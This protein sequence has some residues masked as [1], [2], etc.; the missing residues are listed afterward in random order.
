[1]MNVCTTSRES[2]K[3]RYRSEDIY[4]WIIFVKKVLRAKCLG[5][6]LLVWLDRWCDCCADWELF[7]FSWFSLVKPVFVKNTLPVITILYN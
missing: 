1:M 6:C 3:P 4:Y 7:R 5:M 2:R